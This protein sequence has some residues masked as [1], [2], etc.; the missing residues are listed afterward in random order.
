M[1]L[2]DILEAL[3]QLVDRHPGGAIGCIVLSVALSVSAAYALFCL[4][5][6]RTSMVTK[7]Q[8]AEHRAERQHGPVLYDAT[9]EYER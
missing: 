8:C 9:G 7:E 5:V 6:I 4:H 1:G 2:I 3:L